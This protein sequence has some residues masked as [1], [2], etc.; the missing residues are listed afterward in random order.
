M[1][2]CRKE[3]LKKVKYENDAIMINVQEL[4]NLIVLNDRLT[5]IKYIDILKEN[6]NKIVIRKQNNT[7]IVMMGIIRISQ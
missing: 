2:N 6:F 4:E 5:T 3:F 1:E 7:K